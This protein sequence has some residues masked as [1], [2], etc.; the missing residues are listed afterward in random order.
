MR[1]FGLIIVDKPFGPTS[2]RIVSL[3]RQ[4]TGIRKV[5]HAG[6]LDPRASGVLVLCLGPA[7]RLSEYL[8]MTSKRYEATIRFGATTQTYDG[9]G[10]I[11]RRSEQLPTIDQIQAALPQFMGEIRQAPPP[12][13][14]IKLQGRRAYDMARAGEPVELAPR[15]VTI[16]LLEVADYHAPDLALA[17][18]CSAGTYIRS[19]ANDLGEC[20]GAGAYLAALRRTKAGPFGIDQAVSL[21]ML[22]ESFGTGSWEEYVRPAADALP[23][24]PIIRLDAVQLEGVRHGHRLPAAA[25]SSGMARGLGPDGELAAIL[26]AVEAGSLWH[27][28]K[29]FL[30]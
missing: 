8:S 17:I 29:V 21:A 26:E 9:D 6:T 16:H 28:R 22:E 14:A 1:D 13:S 24:L 4:G 18:E 12:F 27:P 11:V 5:G 7:T 15:S 30:E 3:V 20:L 25:A 10:E 19:L 2:H 23:H